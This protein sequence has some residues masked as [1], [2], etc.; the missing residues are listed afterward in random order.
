MGHARPTISLSITDMFCHPQWSNVLQEVTRG[1]GS[2]KSSFDMQNLFLQTNASS[3]G[4][5]HMHSFST[6]Q[7]LA[8]SSGSQ[9][10]ITGLGERGGQ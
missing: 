3:G 7:T 2:Q 5:I 9:E 4:R 10:F 8:D 1:Q 6:H